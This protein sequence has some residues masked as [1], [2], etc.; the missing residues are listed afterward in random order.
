LRAGAVLSADRLGE[1]GEREREREREKFFFS[2]KGCGGG[3][4]GG[5]G[6]GFDG[7]EDAQVCSAQ[8]LLL[9]QL[10]SLLKHVCFA[11]WLMYAGGLRSEV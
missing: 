10:L 8:L 1:V 6:R 3:G 9:L 5:G 11:P 4:G 7:R 2:P